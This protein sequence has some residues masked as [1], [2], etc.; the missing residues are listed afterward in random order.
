MNKSADTSSKISNVDVVV[1]AA[2]I[3]EAHLDPVDTEDI[4]IVAAQLAPGRFSWKKYKEQ[5]NLEHVR[6]RLFDARKPEMGGYVEGNNDGWSLTEAGASH[7]ANLKKL[8]K[9]IDLSKVVLSRQQ[10]VQQQQQAQW[11]AR[12]RARILNSGIVTRYSEKGADAITIREAESLFRIDEYVKGEP[13]EQKLR[14]WI[15]AFK[16]D[17]E[18]GE[19]V[20]ALANRLMRDKK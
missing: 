7:A 13:R 8:I 14:K 12:E 19:V 11:L 4:A 18:L 20:Q 17:P 6:V 3:L 5:I 10:R 16:S 1:L 2:Y 15:T 9:G